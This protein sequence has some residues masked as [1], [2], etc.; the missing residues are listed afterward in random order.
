[1]QIGLISFAA[2]NTCSG[3]G[4]KEA[5]LLHAADVESEVGSPAGA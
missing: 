5:P 4:S 1:M 3:G 2:R